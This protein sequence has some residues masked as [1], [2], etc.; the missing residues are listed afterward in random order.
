MVRNTTAPARN[1]PRTARVTPRSACITAA[2]ASNALFVVHITSF[3]SRSTPRMLGVTLELTAVS[4]ELALVMHNLAR[5]SQSMAR[6]LQISGAVTS[7]MMVVSTERSGAL[8]SRIAVLPE[9]RR[10][11]QRLRSVFSEPMSVLRTGSAIDRVEPVSLQRPDAGI[12]GPA[13]GESGEGAA[14]RYIYERGTALPAAG[15]AVVLIV[16]HGVHNHNAIEGVWRAPASSG[17]HQPRPPSPGV[18][19]VGDGR[20]GQGVRTQAAATPR[21]PVSARSPQPFRQS[22]REPPQAVR[23]ALGSRSEAPYIPGTTD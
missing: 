7:A 10:L 2:V 22:G 18:G 12:P 16:C 11:V 13:P 23:R 1:T 19:W 6:V 3:A 15:C 9:T 14:V 8:Q 5:V 17:V 20:G 4:L 21:P